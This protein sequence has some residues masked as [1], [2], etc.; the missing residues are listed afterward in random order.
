VFQGDLTELEGLDILSQPEGCLKDA[1]HAYAQAVGATHTFFMTQGSSTGLQAAML[2]C[3]L[4]EHHR[5]LLPR[6]AHRSALSGLILTGAYPDWL[7]PDWCPT[8]G[9]WLGLQARHLPVK[10]PSG[11]KALII[12]SPIYEGLL[13]DIPAI[14]AW[15]KQNNLYCIVDEAHGALWP[16]YPQGLPPSAISMPGVDIV[17]QSGH[18]TLGCLTPGALLHLPQGSS[19]GVDHMQ[20]CINLLHTTS[21]SYPVLASLDAMRHHWQQPEGQAYLQHWWHTLQHLR[22][23]LNALSD[24]QL[25][26]DPQ[27]DASKL[28]IRGLHQPNTDWALQLEAHANLPYEALTQHAALYVW[29]VGLTAKDSERFIES[30]ATLK[31][32]TQKTTPQVKTAYALPTRVDSILSPRQAFFAPGQRRHKT[33]AIGAIARHTQVT[34][35]P[36]VPVVLHGERIQPEHLPHLPDYLEV[37][38]L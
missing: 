22:Q 12:T 4:T 18:K 24:L 17:V 7:Y 23:R 11:C 13:A 29:G 31:T 37:V 20:Q 26:T 15:C 25:Y 34:C 14:A 27:H 9:M 21:P 8:W 6:N 30:F 10:P 33:Q 1:Q 36:G 16:F 32:H 35:P 28:L 2:A 3:G 38:A 19:I 5:V